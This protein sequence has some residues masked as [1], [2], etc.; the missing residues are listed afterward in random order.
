MCELETNTFFYVTSE[1][2]GHYNYGETIEVVR[3]DYL[4]DHWSYEE[5]FSIIVNNDDLCDPVDS[6]TITIS[7]TTS[8]LSDNEIDFT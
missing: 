5:H 7:V 3:Q 8:D 4:A 1:S 2:Y 6:T